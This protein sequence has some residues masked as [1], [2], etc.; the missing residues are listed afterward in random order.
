MAWAVRVSNS[1]DIVIFGKAYSHWHDVD[2]AA[3]T[4]VQ[5]PDYTVSSK[6]DI[7]GMHNLKVADRP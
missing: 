6:Y 2:S 5:V 7:A 3:E 1:Q 4:I